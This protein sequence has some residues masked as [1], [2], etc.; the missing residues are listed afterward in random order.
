MT[1]RTAENCSL[2]TMQ[3]DVPAE[4]ARGPSC[5][6]RL[7]HHVCHLWVVGKQDG[8]CGLWLQQRQFDRPLFPGGFDLTST[9][10]IDQAKRR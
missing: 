8:V 1:A 6:R 2:F 10:H 7:F 4:N 9:G 3:T 5:M